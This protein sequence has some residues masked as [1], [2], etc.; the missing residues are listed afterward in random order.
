MPFEELGVCSRKEQPEATS[1]PPAL[2]YM[3]G[4]WGRGALVSSGRSPVSEPEGGGNNQACA[5]ASPQ[6]PVGGN[7]E[8][9]TGGGD[10]LGG[11]Q[12]RSGWTSGPKPK[13]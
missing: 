11:V 12:A 6:G 10:T 3:E 2:R 7:G 4:K 1:L 13:G 5:D 8:G 9:G